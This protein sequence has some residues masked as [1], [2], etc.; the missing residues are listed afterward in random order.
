MVMKAFWGLALLALTSAQPIDLLQNE[1]IILYADVSPKLRIIT[2]SS[3]FS[4]VMP[5]DVEC[6]FSPK[7]DPSVYTV[8]IVND[9]MLSLTLNPGKK[10]AENPTVEGITLYLVELKIRGENRLNGIDDVAKVVPTPSV[11][12]S[13]QVIYQKATRQFAI[14]GT[15]FNPKR[16]D[17][18]FEPP[19]IRNQDYILNVATTSSLVL[20]RTT[21]SLWR[22][23]PGPLKL[24]RIDTGGGQLRINPNEEGIVVAEV[25]ADLDNHGVTVEST[26]NERSYQSTG[27]IS[28]IGD[29][30]NPTDNHFRFANGL[31]GHGVNY[32]TVEHSANMITMQLKA[33]SK[34]RSNPD[35]LPGPLNL[36]AVDAGAGFVAVGP[37]EAKKGRTVATI[38]EDVSIVPSTK[39]VYSSHSHE[40]W[41]VGKGFT[42]GDY[43]TVLTFD[44]PIEDRM[45]NDITALVFNRTHIRL[46]IYEGE[47]WLDKKITQPVPLRVMTVNT[48]P[49]PI[50]MNGDGSS[51]GSSKSVIGSG[52]GVVIATLQPDEAQHADVQVFRST[53]QSL[54]QTAALKDLKIT[55]KGFKEGMTFNFDNG[56][57]NNVDYKM[58]VD[59]TEQATL[60]LKSARKWRVEGGALRVLSVKLPDEDQPIVVGSGGEGVAVAEILDDPFITSGERIIFATHTKQLTINGY[61]FVLDDTR[62]TLKPTLPDAYYL[63]S[64]EPYRIVLHLR[65]GFSW[66]D[67]VF[68]KGS[69]QDIFVTKID[70]R[71]GEVLLNGGEGV[72]IAKVEADLDDNNCDDSC[73]YAFDGLCDDGTSNVRD[74]YDDDYGGFYGYDDGQYY[75]YGYYYYGDDHYGDDTFLAAICDV[76][77][78]CTDCGGPTH[79]TEAKI[80]ECDNSCQWSNDGFC[81]DERTSGLCSAGTDCHDCGPVGA[82]N[83]TSLFGD[84][85]EWN[86]EGESFWDDDDNYWVGDDEM[87]YAPMDSLEDKGRM[88]DGAGSLFINAMQ[89]IVYFVG[90]VFCTGG[91]FLGFKMYNGEAPPMT[92]PMADEPD[93]EAKS[94]LLTQSGRANVPVTPDV[95]TS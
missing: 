2:K 74:W 93:L 39:V 44:P 45:P 4:G 62:I 12:K 55:G 61:G 56:L 87:A 69:S 26:P 30:F 14:N 38:F 41:I 11:L 86:S 42:R 18:I 80:V 82:S 54:Y 22:S 75:D 67:N 47:S 8:N 59:S 17:L 50:T 49:G 20:T 27:R 40:I 15:N 72:V 79:P 33:G 65:D 90:L 94:S 76:G 89:A 23:D 63:D 51:Y 43:K 34:W 60:T 36:L 68:E 88:N 3:A 31:R 1:A 37:T 29:G 48:G 9:I 13:D 25:Q 83:F 24:R 28:V 95:F 58:K 77:T 5:N 52:K 92:F 57:Y 6:V 73:E 21:N 10:W 16:T 84:D 32:T 91:A 66:D 46:T 7:V 35:N 19:L 81:D 64:V 85:W 78:D 71:A 70:T 53:S